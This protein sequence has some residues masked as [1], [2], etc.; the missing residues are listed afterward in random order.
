[1]RGDDAIKCDK[2]LLIDL[3][4]DHRA[5]G[6]DVEPPDKG[7]VRSIVDAATSPICFVD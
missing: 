2:S 5:L 3:P 4:K 7:K 6:L 1:M